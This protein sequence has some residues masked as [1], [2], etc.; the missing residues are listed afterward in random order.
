MVRSIVGVGLAALAVVS[1]ATAAPPDSTCAKK[2][3]TT[4]TETFSDGQIEGG[5]G[6]NPGS[7][8]ESIQPRGGNPQEYLLNRF[9]SAAYPIARTE[10]G[11]E[12]AFTG[13]YRERGVTE[14]SFDLNAY[15]SNL[16]LFAERYVSL[17]LVNDS[18]TPEVFEDDCFVFFTSDQNMPDPTQQ[19]HPERPQWVEYSFS[20]PSDS[21]TLPE[22]N[23]VG[24]CPECIESCPALGEPCWGWSRDTLCPTRDDAQLTWNTVI[25]DV[26]QVWISFQHP[27]YFSLIQDWSV[28]LDNPSI[29][30]CS[31]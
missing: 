24:E 6:F 16:N 17:V 15:R 20:I 2:F 4:V 1:T 27:E 31:Q 25:Q 9:L 12:S 7:D 3:T 8:F 26:D 21:P 11:L 28:G 19:R 23:H 29:T 10:L 14:I 30:T 18:G 22:P 13:N 5:W